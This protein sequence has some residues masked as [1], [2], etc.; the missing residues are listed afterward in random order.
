PRPGLRGAGAADELMSIPFPEIL[1][2]FAAERRTDNPPRDPVAADGS[3]PTPRTPD[4]YLLADP[5]RQRPDSPP[6]SLRLVLLATGPGMP[7]QA[8]PNGAMA[9]AIDMPAQTARSARPWP[10]SVP[11]QPRPAKGGAGGSPHQPRKN[12]ADR[13]QA[14]ASG[15]PGW[16]SASPVNSTIL[17]STSART[18]SGLASGADR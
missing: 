6:A 7:R 13:S 8:T 12:A 5:A 11:G 3:D 10:A 17:R 1:R 18:V 4:A 2:A 15:P 14:P 16:L 9:S